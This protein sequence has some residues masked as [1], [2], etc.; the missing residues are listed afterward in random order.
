MYLFSQRHIPAQSQVPVV[1]S[2]CLGFLHTHRALLSD[3]W[4]SRGALLGFPLPASIFCSFLRRAAGTGRVIFR[5]FPVT[6]LLSI[7][8]C[9][10]A[11]LTT[12]STGCYLFAWRFF[13]FR[14]RTACLYEVKTL[15]SL[16]QQKTATYTDL[17][18]VY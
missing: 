17:S 5:R 8:L 12:C 3:C 2:G 1:V 6:C 18:N 4:K 7:F 15:S 16:V 14:G 9:F 10:C 11:F 13:T